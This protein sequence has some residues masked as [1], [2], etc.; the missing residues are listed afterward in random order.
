MLNKH[1]ATSVV[2]HWVDII[3][4]QVIDQFILTFY[5]S[6][7]YKFK[8]DVSNI[9]DTDDWLTKAAHEAFGPKNKYNKNP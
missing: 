4:S 3:A 1:W 9:Q 7:E 8:L 6:N 5:N 2:L